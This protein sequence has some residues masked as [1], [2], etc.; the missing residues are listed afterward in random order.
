MKTITLI[1]PYATLVAIG[2]KKIETRSWQTNY[3]GPLAI[4]AAKGFPQW[5]KD[6][7]WSPPVSVM[8]GRDYV[9]PLGQVVAV[10]NLVGVWSTLLLDKLAAHTVSDQERRFGDYSH[11]R[12]AWMLQ[13]IKALDPPIA[14]KGSQGFW[15]WEA[16][17]DITFAAPRKA[18]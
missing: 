9:Y 8:L 14:A 18:S 16:E 13:N 5:A 12:F 4:H 2:A 6:F 10:C 7:A 11:G 1:Q 15:N 17:G 3:C